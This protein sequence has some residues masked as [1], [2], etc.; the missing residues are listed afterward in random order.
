MNAL[1][2]NRDLTRPLEEVIDDMKSRGIE[3]AGEILNY[4]NVR[5]VSA[6]AMGSQ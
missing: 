4:E 2:Y 5:L 1:D 3:F 6:L